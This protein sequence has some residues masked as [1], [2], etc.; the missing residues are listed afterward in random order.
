VNPR[1]D[2]ERSHGRIAGGAALGSV[3][4][5]LGA[6][7]LA[8]ASGGQGSPVNPGAAVGQPTPL[9]RAQQLLS[10]HAGQGDQAIATTLR[11]LGLALTA[12]V[13][14]Y[15]Y[16]VARARRPE[17]SRWML[18]TAVAGSALV[19]ASTVFG[20]FALGHVANVFVSSG[21]RSSARAHHLIDASG[22]LRAAAVFD[23]VS[24]LGFALW[25][26]LASL[27]LMR[28]GLLDRFLGYWGFGA[29]AALVLLP[30]GDAMFI[31]WLGSVG[32]IA[33]GYW[34][35]GRPKAWSRISIVR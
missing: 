16:S 23:V 30:I 13:G 22:P 19:V 20:Y 27:E 5:W 2:S 8:N 21:V 26:G 17:I 15:L 9:D 34:P 33:L 32:V 12:A 24:R 18:G 14:V 35:G 10:F 4:C 29:C 31:G 6:L 1:L 7:A 25:I 28:V 3:A 11:C